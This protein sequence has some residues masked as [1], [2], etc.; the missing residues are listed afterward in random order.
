MLQHWKNTINYSQRR[1][2]QIAHTV[3]I[4]SSRQHT[5]LKRFPFRVRQCLEPETVFQTSVKPPFLI[6]YAGPPAP[7]Q[8]V[9]SGSYL[10]TAATCFCAV[11]CSKLL[12]FSQTFLL[13]K[14][15]CST[16]HPSCLVLTS[17]FQPTPLL[18]QD[19]E[20]CV[21]ATN[22]EPRKQNLWDI[23]SIS[24][25]FILKF[26]WRFYSNFAIF[27]AKFHSRDFR[28]RSAIRVIFMVDLHIL[29]FAAILFA[30]I[31]LKHCP[32]VNIFTT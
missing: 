14:R 2:P 7:A 30:A 9:T 21:N 16:R 5:N 32:I 20:A 3:A 1:F 4:L 19:Q 31:M 6:A 25:L 13:S 28:G 8:L 26:W 12:E 23:I 18:S 17:C 15:T 11:L 29:Y 22:S 10:R 24:P 27:P